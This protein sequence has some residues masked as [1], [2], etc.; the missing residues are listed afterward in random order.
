M[1]LRCLLLLLLLSVSLS[2]LLDTICAAVV[3]FL[4]ALAIFL[5]VMASLSIGTNG[6]S[7]NSISSLSLV[8]NSNRESW[9]SLIPTRPLR[10]VTPKIRLLILALRAALI[11]FA[12]NG[13]S[14]SLMYIML[15][16]FTPANSSSAIIL[17]RSRI[18]LI[19]IILCV[20]YVNWT[21]IL[22]P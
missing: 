8:M 17:L 19:N 9:F 20:L 10:D 16:D 11:R 3:P 18:L 4:V 1:F 12:K 6:L 21:I 2:F 22:L 7:S 14:W 5:V 15:L 13:V